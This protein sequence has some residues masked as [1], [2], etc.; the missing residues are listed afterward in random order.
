M[1][2]PSSIAIEVPQHRQ[3]VADRRD[4]RPVLRVVHER[5][6]VGVVEQVAQLGLD[7]PVVDVD[8]DRPQLVRGEDRLDELEAV[9]R[10]D[11]D[12]VARP[13][14]VAGEVVR[15]PVRALLELGVGLGPVA[16]DDA[17]PDR[18]RHRRC[19]R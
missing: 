16:H 15:E 4:A 10:V 6:Q 8:R 11:A 3:R 13:D 2:L 14:A 18:G 1:P 7:V 9:E 5:H 19:V 17:R 12:V